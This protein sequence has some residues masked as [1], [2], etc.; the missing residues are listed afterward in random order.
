[1]MM[2]LAHGAR[3]DIPG[4]PYRD[5]I[6]NVWQEAIQ[7][8]EAAAE[9]AV[10]DGAA[11]QEAVRAGA[12]VH[13]MGKLHE[14]NQAVLHIK[15]YNGILPVHHQ[16]A[17]VA[18]LK[19]S[20]TNSFSAQ[21]AVSAHHRGLPNIYS[22]IRRKGNYFRD[23]DA[24]LRNKV[25]AEIGNLM[26]LSQSITELPAFSFEN[27]EIK[28]DTGVFW[29]MMLSCLTDADHTDTARHYRKYPKK[30]NSALPLLKAEER[31]RRLNDYVAQFSKKEERDRLRAE[32]FCFCRDSMIKA[33]I[34]SCDSPV[35]SAKTTALMAHALRQ[36]ILRKARRIFVVLPFTNII[37][38]SVEIY[39]D[40]LT[41]T[42]EKPEEVVAEL[43]HRADFESE[44][45][46][47]LT[48][49][50]KSPIIV[51]TAVAFFETL[52]SNKPSGLRRLHELPG[53]II[54]VDEAHAALP[55]R[56]LP[57]AWHWIQV[58]AD[59]WSCYWI[60]ASG[61]LVEFWKLD[62]I[63]KT[64]RDVPQIV[65]S[66]LRKKLQ[67]YEARR[68]RYLFRKEPLSRTQ[69][70]EWVA[71]VPGPRLLVMNTVQSAAVIAQDMRKFYGP[72]QEN[73]VMHLSH[74]LNAQ[75]QEKIIEKVKD[76]LKDKQDMDWTLVATSCFEAGVNVSF[77][78]GFR[79]LASLLS[80][81]QLAGR[82]NRSGDDDEAVIWSFQMQEDPLLTCNRELRDAAYVLHSY[83][84]RQ[85]P[86]TPEL[87]TKA[88]EDELRRQAVSVEAERLLEGEHSNQFL[89][90]KNKFRVIE[91]DTVFVIADTSLKEQ[92]CRGERDWKEIQRK[93]IAVRKY[94][95]SQFGLKPLVDGIY[96]WN[97][98]YD[99]FLGIMKGILDGL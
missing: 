81:L 64:K 58:L 7:Y 8:A 55:V 67:Q 43:H 18:C 30:Q 63:S 6:R 73:K 49:Q 57:T 97:L 40:A 4:Q 28:G 19:K 32:M 61:T 39:R 88:L 5:H 59:E 46:R 33:N 37:S 13:D 1:M 66:A 51:T 92:L 23:D 90:V 78:I 31:L 3:G 82:I 20:D 24:K 60:L 62:R 70:V 11:L 52:A 56:L 98:G 25:D 93:A 85:I 65:S 94:R 89:E 10:L 86:I 21:L 68:V 15:D 54:F 26:A 48:A 47:A 99:D 12:S 83:F 53:S 91:E 2:Y 84:E 41:L 69:L 71:S 14:E 72:G 17:G 50:W 77:K 42:G 44:D 36:A 87:S 9:Y 80:L 45:T 27:C 35:G 38:Q 96:D 34:A 16:D 79:E 95:V 29:R 75:D 74:A 76:R 22:E